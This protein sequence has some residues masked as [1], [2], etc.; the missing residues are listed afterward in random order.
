MTKTHISSFLDEENLAKRIEEGFID[1]KKHPEA[2]LYIHNYT[3]LAQF[4]QG[5]MSDP[6]VKTSRGLILDQDGFVVARPFTK[7]HNIHEHPAPGVTALSGLVPL[8]TEEPFTA[9]AKMDGSLGIAYRVNGEIR[10]AT[11][12]SFSSPQALWATE[13]YRANYA[14]A[15]I[16]EGQTYLFEIIYPAGQIVISYD[17]SDLVL[18]AVLD[19]E[20]G[21]D[22]PLP[23]SWPG[24]VVEQYQFEDFNAVAKMA[25]TNPPGS[26]NTEGFVIR[27]TESGV[28]T[29]VKFAEYMMLHRIVSDT[30]SLT[31]H[32][33]LCA[34]RLKDK[35]PLKVIAD[36]IGAPVEDAQALLEGDAKALL[37]EVTPDEMY[38]WLKGQIDKLETAADGMLEE[39][40][41][42][43]RDRKLRSLDRK[44]ASEIIQKESGG[45]NIKMLFILLSGHN[46]EN[47]IW[48]LIRPEYSRAYLEMNNF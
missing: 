30:T 23:A 46:P 5:L 6:A 33:H 1:K 16:P 29:K 20:T 19:N 22:L 13:H 27:F 2:P 44:V 11:R 40:E 25:N 15:E 36:A 34:S 45:L 3:P 26:R 37:L 10:I 12:G 9:Y 32:R 41:A 28:R 38:P 42:F 39:H 14:A 43:I 48:K 47:M 17:F 24:R 7:F 21:R 31:V 18:L 4:T 8:P 35:Y